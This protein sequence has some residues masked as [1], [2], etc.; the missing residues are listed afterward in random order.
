MRSRRLL[1]ALILLTYPPAL[2]CQSFF[3]TIEGT[4][5]D[6]H[7]KVAADVT[8]VIHG[9]PDSV[10]K[11][12]ADPGG[13]FTATLPYGEYKISVTARNFAASTE[14]RVEA[15]QIS[16]CLLRLGQATV[17]PPKIDDFAEPFSISGH[18]L[19][20]DPTTVVQPLNL[21]G[22]SDARLNLVS[23]RAFTWTWSEYTL[24][25]LDITDSYQPGYPLALGDIESLENVSANGSVISL[26]VKQS[27]N[28]WHG[29][30]STTATGSVL[31]FDN[32]PPPV[33][34]GSV[35][36][37]EHFNW[38]T[39]DNVQAGGSIGNRAD[40]FL[41]GTGQW[42]SQTVPVAVR[43]EDQ[44]NR[45]LFGNARG[46]IQLTPKDQLD[47]QY[48]GS[49]V[50][51]SNWTQP[52]GLESLTGWRMLPALDI[53]P[54]GFAGL[55]EV[56]HLDSIQNGWTHQFTGNALQL[57]Y[58][59]VPTH[60]DTTDGAAGGQSK[61]DLLNGIVVG[62]PPLTNLAIRTSQ[63]LGAA[64]GT[65][66][67]HSGVMH[68]FA[69]SSTIEWSKSTNRFRS[70]EDLLLITA[71]GVPADV[72]ELNAPLDSK[73]HVT[74]T[75]V[76][77]Q[78]SLRL[79]SSFAVNVGVTADFSRGSLPAQSS[80]DGIYFAQR[81]FQASGDLMSW[82]TASP[83]V[84]FAFNVPGLTSL[85]LRGTYNRMYAPLAARYLDYGNPN[86]ISGSVYQWV[87]GNGDGQFQPNERGML[88]RRFGGNV[89]SIDTSLHRPYADEF[90]VAA[91]VALPWRTSA[92][93]ELY[94]RDDKNRIAAINTGVPA[95]AYV[96]VVINDPGPDSIPGTFDDQQ[97][98]VWNQNPATF[99][100]DRY[101]LTN[102]KGF[103]MLYEGLVARFATEH[104]YL[105]FYAAFTAEK[106]YGPTNPGNG[107]L[108]NDP[109]V[110]G[111]LYQ[112]PNT[113][114]HAAGRDFFDRAFLGKVQTVSRLP[115]W[116]GG[117]ELLNT[118]NY[119][120]GLVFARQLLISGL[121]QGPF[122]VPATVRGSPEGGNRAEY[123]LNWNL[124]LRRS[125]Q[126]PH[127]RME[128]S[129]DVMN[130]NNFGNRMQ[131]SDVSGPA[132]NQRLP[133][134]IQPARFVRLGVSYEF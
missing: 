76:Y 50:N 125:F 52:A 86:S 85:T 118:V 84:G 11:L 61:A 101:L 35:T 83:V 17:P 34:R 37:T 130:V 128:T 5:R 97:L 131:E 24:Q 113:L 13:R 102:P 107:V 32:L 29:K 112:D 119:L 6:E 26:S 27:G 64:F 36:Q 42:S 103:R 123:V 124:R 60:L 132:F 70:P 1:F 115:Q 133:V 33:T 114:I 94:R 75:R 91:E 40:I 14:I 8:V 79:A 88:L 12:H 127:G 116:L 93:I 68:R 25:G 66:E 4:V 96:P 22:L 19:A 16:R 18:L 134:A 78:D 72:V 98:T 67:I 23:Q 73:G 58:Q 129:V 38:F 49:R 111:A 47:A 20:R 95:S 71:S 109:G 31:A 15:G 55:G 104:R 51:T 28:R 81:R 100:N 110:V 59:F 120:D 89:S 48:S 45:L 121:D 92:Q 53:N 39:R 122:V 46:R 62:P 9:L 63:Q 117:V 90:K 54:Y 21:T 30:V 3:G 106:T 80:P 43:G 2:I 56:D 87:D 10:L 57:R 82:D 41:S 99:G 126:L 69:I 108:E 105:S 74:S 77:F 44:N 7:D 65:R